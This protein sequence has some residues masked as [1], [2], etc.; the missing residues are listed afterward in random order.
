VLLLFVVC[1]VCCCET[2]RMREQREGIHYTINSPPTREAAAGG[3]FIPE[4]LLPCCPVA[5]SIGPSAGGLQPLASVMLSSGSAQLSSV[6]LRPVTPR[7]A[8]V[9]HSGENGQLLENG[10]WRL[11]RQPHRPADLSRHLRQAACAAA[12]RAIR[13][14]SGETGAHASA[15]ATY[16]LN[17]RIYIVGRRSKRPTSTCAQHMQLLYNNHY[18]GVDHPPPGSQAA[19][20]VSIRAMLLLLRPDPHLIRHSPFAIRPSSLRAAQLPL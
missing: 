1:V 12:P 16:T 19:S 4:Q 5:L 18:R 3:P 10:K 15:H 6:V 20:T 2:W 9:L 13:P 8:P 11:I 7:V 17:T 14:V